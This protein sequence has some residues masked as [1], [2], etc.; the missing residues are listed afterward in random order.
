MGT[1]VIHERV[2]PVAVV[3]LDRAQRHNSLVPEF[4]A[5]IL[6]ALEEVRASSSARAMVLQANGRSFS[7]GGDVAGF[8]A[9]LDTLEAYAGRIVGLLN[10]TI[11]A[12]LK[13]PAPVVAAVQGIVTGGS[14]GLVLG[15]DL[16]LVCHPN[17]V[18][19]LLSGGSAPVRDAASALA[20]LYGRPTVGR[21][22]L[23][24]VVAEGIREWGHWQRSLEA[25]NEQSWT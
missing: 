25:L 13:L 17:E 15:C 21:E 16:V 1:W 6:A 5:E 3:T 7:T 10:E 12:L 20:R 2:G 18:E 22:Q 11:L 9:H 19:E 24:A 8:V 14:L 23:Q 4:L